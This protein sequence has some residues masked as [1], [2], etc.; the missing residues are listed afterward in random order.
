MMAKKD[1]SLPKISLGV[2]GR[3]AS[4]R[5]KSCAKV[6]ELWHQDPF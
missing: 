1:K 5:W 2:I 4:M 3:S 6:R